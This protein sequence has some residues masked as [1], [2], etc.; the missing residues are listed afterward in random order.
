MNVDCE[1]LHAVLLGVVYD[2]TADRK[3][4]AISVCWWCFLATRAA[5]DVKHSQLDCAH[6]VDYIAAQGGHTPLGA[7]RSGRQLA[8]AGGREST[9]CSAR[10]K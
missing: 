3:L 1:T 6:A 9:L 7:R 5:L 10:A 8:F 4:G 2:R